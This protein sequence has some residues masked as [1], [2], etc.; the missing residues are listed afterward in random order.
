MTNIWLLNP[1]AELELASLAARNTAP[2]ASPLAA[3]ATM[4]KRRA[5]FDELTLGEPALLSH[6]LDQL[7]QQTADESSFLLWCP[8]PSLL[9]QCRYYELRVPPSPPSSLLLAVNDKRRLCEWG[10][11][12]VPE[13]ILVRQIED[14]R[15]LQKNHEIVRLKRPFGFAGR[16]QRRITGMLSADD[17]R[18]IL[19]S[20]KNG[21]L[22]A[23]PELQGFL[24]K[25]VHV[26][27][28]PRET[29]VGQPLGFAC[30]D[31]GAFQRWE[32][33]TASGSEDEAL[34]SYA[35]NAAAQLLCRGYFGP[36]AIDFVVHNTD[37][38]YALDLN[39]RFSLGW[40]RGMGNLRDRAL[41][42]YRTHGS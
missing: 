10:L 40:S 30:D 2:Y 21:S 1:D 11:P 38:I 26:L 33:Q 23:E 32:A 39:G 13:R 28:H 8:T 12:V 35:R 7:R 34:R 6:E 37:R 22:V 9:R 31:F 36:A 41:L 17:T 29:L 16:G 24:L 42:L 14:L 27:V 3:R 15:A 25:S 19:D 20:L 18:W 4:S 5:V